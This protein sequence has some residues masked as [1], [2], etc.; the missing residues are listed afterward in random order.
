[1]LRGYVPDALPLSYKDEPVTEGQTVNLDDALIMHLT[2]RLGAQTCAPQGDE[3]PAGSSHPSPRGR[4]SLA[5]VQAAGR[6]ETRRQ[7]G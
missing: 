2:K 3:A 1:M 6:Q 4:D 5:A 7:N